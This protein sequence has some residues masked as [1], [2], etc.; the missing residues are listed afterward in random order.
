MKHLLGA[1]AVLILCMCG[2][3][4]STAG[5]KAVIDKSDQ[6]MFVWVDGIF[7][8]VWLASTG[9]KS[10]YTPTGQFHPTR[11]YPGVHQ[12]SKYG[13]NMYWTV[14]YEVRG[15]RAVHGVDKLEDLEALGNYGTSYG[16]THLTVEHA[17]LFYDLTQSYKRSQVEIIIQE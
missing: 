4:P 5:V 10:A 11:F 7:R 15:V 12:S 14:Y 6:L 8:Y 2:A 3:T 16:C 1:L 9:K 17:K 13:S